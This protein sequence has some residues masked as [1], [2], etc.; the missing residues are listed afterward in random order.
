MQGHWCGS[1]YMV[2]RLSD[3]KQPKNTKNAC[4]WAYIRQPH[5]HKMFFEKILRIGAAGIESTILIFFSQNFF[6]RH[7]KENKQPILM[8]YHFFLHYGWFFQNFGKEA[9]RT[10]MHT[11][12]YGTWNA[13]SK[14][15][16]THCVVDLKCSPLSR[17]DFW[18]N[19]V[20]SF[21]MV[22]FH[23]PANAFKQFVLLLKVNKRLNIKVHIF[24]EGQKNFAKSPPYFV[25]C[26]ASKM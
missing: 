18:R 17:T 14:R 3:S 19:C 7:L 1:T 2:V 12:V 9:V 20:I 10:N 25:P 26:S 13:T 11:T 4:F 24:S 8:R 22:N 6:L 15:V 16:S 21:F 23:T 5:D